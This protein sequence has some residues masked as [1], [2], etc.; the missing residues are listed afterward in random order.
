MKLVYR[1]VY[2]VEDQLPKGTLPS[3]AVRFKEPETSDKINQVALLFVLPSLVV[4]ALVMIGSAYLHGRVNLSIGV[5]FSISDGISIFHSLKPLFIFIAGMVLSFLV[6]VPHEFLH[7]IWFGKNA[8]VELFIAPK[9]LMLFVISTYPVTKGR[10]IFLSLFPN[11][12]FGWLPLIVWAMLPYS[13]VYSNLLYPF[14]VLSILAGIGDYLNVFNAIRQMPKGSMQQLSGF[15][16]Y[17]FM[18]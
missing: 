17:W 13:E 5:Y 2:K 18:P 9:N 7:G 6:I 11:L 3:N 15:H 4:V 14:A 1:G 12:L 10:F 8:E 16:S